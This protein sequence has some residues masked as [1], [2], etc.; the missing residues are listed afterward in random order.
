ME[1]EVN[2][3][4]SKYT[5]TEVFESCH[6]C[7]FVINLWSRLFLKLTRNLACRSQFADAVLGDFV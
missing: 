5:D 2:E 1:N 7:V 3:D 6:V 4:R